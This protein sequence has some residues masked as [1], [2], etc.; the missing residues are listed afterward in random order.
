MKKFK[1]DKIPTL[2]GTRLRSYA[3]ALLTKREYSKAEFTDKLLE[4]AIDTEEV[5]A[6]VEEFSEK[7]YQS[8]ERVAQMVLSSQTSRGKGPNR[9]KQTL[10]QKKI[11]SAYIAQDIEEVDWVA[12]AY[13]LKLKKFGPEI[14]KDPKQKAKQIRFLQYRGFNMEDILKVVTLDEDD[15]YN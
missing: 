4:Y 15:F 11:D 7:N 9:V 3:Y 1:Q 2:K 8:D 13:K 10:Q 6:L 14:T 12:E 5:L